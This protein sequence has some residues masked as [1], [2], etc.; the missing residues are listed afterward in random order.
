MILQAVLNG[1]LFGAVYVCIGMGFSL[2]WGVMNIINLA[3]GSFIMLGAYITYTLFT[4]F[5]IDPF[6]TLPI[7]M[8]VLYFI[9]YASQKYLLNYIIRASIF[10]TLTFTFGLQILIANVAL[11][12]WTADFK[13]AA[14][15]YSGQGIVL[16]GLVLPY[17]RCAIFIVALILTYLFYLL[18]ARTKTG[19]AINAT[20]LNLE[21]AKTVG[22]DVAEIY[23][24]TMGISAAL[25]GAAGALISPIMTINPFIGGP[26]V[27]K[28]FVVAILGGLGGTMG[29]L[30][31]GMA[32]GLAEQV[33]SIFFS[34]GYQE[35]IGFIVL[36]LV[37]IFRP[38]GIIGK[39]F[40]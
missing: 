23:A 17:I 9:G 32:L 2:V 26:L 28:A 31:G 34:A 21:G 12:I 18:M 27:G 37:L 10:I 14:P 11:L 6:L 35:A 36:V 13:S 5:K 1:I 39:R 3:H 20:A 29:S 8:L 33:G 40:Y 25:G 30:A 19:K 24:R 7:S 22:V 4:Y 38:Q 15:G 16:G